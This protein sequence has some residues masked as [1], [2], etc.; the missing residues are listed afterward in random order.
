M[1]AGQH[2]YVDRKQLLREIIVQGL[3]PNSSYPRRCEERVFE[4]RSN[5][6]GVFPA[7]DVRCR[8]YGIASSFA[9]SL[10]ATTRARD[11]CGRAPVE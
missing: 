6:G 2:R 10:L 4:R 1:V 9:D 5:L 8:R 3:V 7:I 11:L